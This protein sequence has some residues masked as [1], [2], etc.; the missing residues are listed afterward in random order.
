MVRILKKFN[1]ILNKR[2]KRNVCVLFFLMI[3]S[4]FL[5]VL[6]VTLMIP[7]LAT[8]MNPEE[9]EANIVAVKICH[10]LDIDSAFTFVLLCI[11]TLILVF[12]FK[13]LF[14]IFQYYAQCHFV[15][16]CRFMMQSQILKNYLHRRY[17]F[18][19]HVDSGE[20]L[21]TLQQ[22]IDGVYQLLLG[23]LG[24]MSEIIVS[25]TL[26]LA[27][28]VISPFMTVCVACVLVITVLV[29]VK[30]VKPVLQK[31]GHLRQATYADTNK[32]IMQ[33]IHGIKDVKIFKQEDFFLKR[34]EKGSRK[35][36]MALE[37]EGVFQNIPRLLIEMCCVCSMLGVIAV[38][39][40]L[41]SSMASLI[42]V[43]GAFAMAAVKLLPS[44]NRI[45]IAYNNI[46]YYELA[47]DGLLKNMYQTEPMPEKLTENEETSLPRIESQIELCDITYA[48]PGTDVSVLKEGNMCIPIGKSIGLVGMSGSGK[49]TVIDILMG[50]LDVQGGRVLI[51][52][53]DIHT[54]YDSWL[55]H[56]G[57]IPQFIFMLDGSIRDNVAFGREDVDDMKI[58]DALREA[59]LDAFVHGLP[60]GLDTEI[61]E[62]GIRLSG[63]Q[64]QRVGIARALFRNP[65][66]LIFDEATS[67]LD[68]ETE[69]GIMESINTL[70]GKKTMVIVAHRL[71]TIEGCDMV[72]CVENGKIIKKR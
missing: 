39:L 44:A 27:V 32:W 46:A 34:F 69:L 52:G 10:F 16:N 33:S 5:E 72:Y 40:V 53:K 2:Q 9:I 60:R 3:V 56:I 54:C 37:K 67:A 51:D 71:T 30:K 59:K 47:L 21:R 19:L 11:I 13:D 57:Y 42:P 7:L 48:Y 23:V 4:A 70:K 17:E 14:L 64:R 31:A 68:T 63:G 36:A 25:I 29:I 58:W 18:F 61:G 12:I 20:I 62:H 8:A 41:G 66:I 50:L 38:M 26:V 65:D 24:M 43:L 15:Y 6:G 1:Q 45:V 55:L 35:L 49:T 28:F 22:D